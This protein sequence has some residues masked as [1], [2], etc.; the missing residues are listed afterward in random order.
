MIKV[1]E[2]GESSTKSKYYPKA[3]NDWTVFTHACS[4]FSSKVQNQSYKNKKTPPKTPKK[5]QEANMPLS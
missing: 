1:R 5:Q 3:Q 2:R 4:R